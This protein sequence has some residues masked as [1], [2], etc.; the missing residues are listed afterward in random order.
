MKYRSNLGLKRLRVHSDDRMQ[1]K[2]FVAFIGLIIMVSIHETMRKK[3]MFIQMTMDEPINTPARLRVAT[4]NGK[5]VLHPA[6]KEDHFGGFRYF[7]AGLE[8]NEA[9]THGTEKKRQKRRG[10]LYRQIS[11]YVSIMWHPQDRF[12]ACR[13][14]RPQKT[15]PED[16]FPH[17]L[18]IPLSAVCRL[19]DPTYPP[20]KILTPY[21]PASSPVPVPGNFQMGDL[22]GYPDRN[23]SR[24]K[25]SHLKKTIAC[26]KIRRRALP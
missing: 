4:V 18:G 13:T 1:N 21:L 3:E 20:S 16:A 23:L 19:Q 5:T 11:S 6:T 26:D 8:Y 7:A 17:H 22:P 25:N 2:I 14:T 24:R 9:S 12:L 15:L 10:S